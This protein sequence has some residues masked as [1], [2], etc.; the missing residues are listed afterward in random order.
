MDVFPPSRPHPAPPPAPPR[1]TL[2]PLA[3]PTLPDSFPY[4][5]NRHFFCFFFFVTVRQKNL[6][7]AVF[8]LAAIV[9][10]HQDKREEEAA[11]ADADDS[12]ES[13]CE[14]LAGGSGGG[15]GDGENDG[16]GWL[17]PTTTRW[18]IRSAAEATTARVPARGRGGPKRI[19]GGGVRNLVGGGGGTGSADGEGAGVESLEVPL[20]RGEGEASDAGRPSSPTPP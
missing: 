8:S 6:P 3:A 1:N 17:S 19:F 4:F 20:L 16:D 12:V 9:A 18:E 10:L 2:L 13:D 11:A 14:P 5:I 7:L 15:G